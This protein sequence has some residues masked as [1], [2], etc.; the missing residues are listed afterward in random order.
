MKNLQ[1]SGTI[2]VQNAV[3]Q[4]GTVYLTIPADGT[5]KA[6]VTVQDRLK[7]YEAVSEYGEE[8]PSGER[9]KVVKVVSGNI[10]VVE[11]M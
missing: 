2:D 11:K 7:V 3:G 1:S 6:Q 10:L 4:E 8:I 5:G 9:I